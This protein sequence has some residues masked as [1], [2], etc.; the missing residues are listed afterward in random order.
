MQRFLHHGP[1]RLLAC[2]R[3]GRIRGRQTSPSSA[4]L[5]TPGSAALA[6]PGR[7]RPEFRAAERGGAPHRTRVRLPEHAVEA[8]PGAA[9]GEPGRRRLRRQL[10]A[11]SAW[12]WAPIR[13]GPGRSGA[14]HARRPLRAGAAQGQP[15]D[16]DGKAFRNLDGTHRLPARLLGRRLPARAGRAGGR[17]QPALRRTAAEAAGRPRRCGGPGRRRRPAPGARAAGR[18]DR[19]AAVAAARKAVFP[20]AVPRFRGAPAGAGRTDLEDASPRC[21]TAPPT[22]SANANWRRRQSVSAGAYAGNR[23]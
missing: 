7:R 11:A 20:D 13:G 5:R 12:R 14:A 4:L 8:L 23:H 9:Q 10:L 17:G 19:G 18:A 1:D 15:V 16:W 22:A 2:G 21:A 3:R 6:H